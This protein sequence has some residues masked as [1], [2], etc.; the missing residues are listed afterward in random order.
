[1][2]AH[3]R[4]ELWDDAL[5]PLYEHVTRERNAEQ[6]IEQWR[7]GH[8]EAIA[9]EVRQNR[10][11][12]I[13][14][15]WLRGEPW[16][17][18]D[19]AGAEL[20][21]A[22]ASVDPQT[23]ALLFGTLDDAANIAERYGFSDEA[24]WLRS[25][26]ATLREKGDYFGLRDRLTS[27]LERQRPEIDFGD[28]DC[29]ADLAT[30]ILGRFALT[31]QKTGAAADEE[32]RLAREALDALL[33]GIGCPRGMDAAGRDRLDDRLRQSSASGDAATD[34]IR[35]GRLAASLFALRCAL[36][37]MAAELPHRLTSVTL[38][39]EPAFR[40][41]AAD[42]SRWTHGWEE[43]PGEEAAADQPQP[44]WNDGPVP[45]NRLRWKKETHT[46]QPIP[47][48]LLDFMWSRE[49]AAEDD[50]AVHVWGEAEAHPPSNSALK[51]AISRA[52]DALLS[53]KIPGALGQNNGY[54]VWTSKNF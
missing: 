2:S 15:R 7:D 34:A 35:A 30:S 53:V 12:E 18:A 8:S 4:R 44:V 50:V 10:L 36:D 29:I 38:P 25:T 17:E 41:A 16:V 14:E 26:Y 22:P 9:A 21:H 39:G 43:R 45:P 24:G 20:D 19:E 46:V 6:R 49:R 32:F 23:W 33:D 27:R 52:N 1:M 51:S 13:G 40:A 47:W 54:I 28:L 5:S 3:S 48:R 31:R 11:I 37:E 42:L